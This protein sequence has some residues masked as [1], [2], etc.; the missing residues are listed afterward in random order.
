MGFTTS[1]KTKSSE[2]FVHLGGGEREKGGGK[3]KGEESL[4]TSVR[5]KL[6]WEKRTAG[7]EGRSYS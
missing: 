2:N 5:V 6:V 7:I 4:K 1:S 3:K